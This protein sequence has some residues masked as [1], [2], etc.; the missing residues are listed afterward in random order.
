M[1]YLE[2]QL[3]ELNQR[4]LLRS[5]SASSG[6]DFSSND[7]LG[8]SKSDLI[9]QRL[10]KFL[11]EQECPR[12]GATGSRLIS[13]EN[14]FTHSTEEYLAKE[15]LSESCLIFGS[16][17]LASL[18]VINSLATEGT[19]FFSDEF[20]HASLIDGM[21]LTKAPVHVFRHNDLSNLEDL[22]K[23]VN[24]RRRIVVTES[25]FSMD[26][27]SPDIDDLLRLCEKFNAFLILDESHATGVLGMRG[28]GITETIGKLPDNV[29]AIHPCGKALGAYGAFVNCSELVRGILINRAR[30]FI[31]STALPSYTLAHIRFASEMSLA[32]TRLRLQLKYHV[33]ILRELLAQVG[34]T[35]HGNHIGHIFVAGNE[36][37]IQASRFLQS[38][39]LSVR[40]IRYP[41]VK[42]GS[43]RLRIVTKSFHSRDDLILLTSK[44]GELAL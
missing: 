6:I 26:G 44:L 27:D 41:T 21:R 12:L 23:S 24:C 15:F 1:I 40:P 37:C 3:Q 14:E 38:C 33:S 4:H 10:I 25:V 43:E 35:L 16:G 9:H 11:Q 28:I 13:G 17:Y 31:Y 7:Y 8:L 20:N 2:Q 18:G 34:I 19:S 22:L 5:L 29:I 32:A 30:T 42:K 36:H 39:G